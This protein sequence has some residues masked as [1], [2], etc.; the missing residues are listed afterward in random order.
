VPVLSLG[1]RRP[2]ISAECWIADNATIIGSVVLRDNASVWF[3]CV[4]RGDNDVITV[5][6]GSNIQD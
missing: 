4:L 3:N 6:E 2:D 1:E 5:G